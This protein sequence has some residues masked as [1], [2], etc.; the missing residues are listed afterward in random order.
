MATP[1]ATIVEWAHHALVAADLP[2]AFGGALALAYHVEE[3]RGTRDIDINVFVPAARAEDVL[4]ALDRA[5]WDAKDL[6]LALRDGQVRVFYED[7][8]LDLFLMNHPF[9]VQS[10]TNVEVVPFLDG[11]IPIL[12]ATDLAVYKV[13]FNRTK[14]WADLEAM[15]EV[16][17]FD[18]HVVLGWVVDL[19]GGD[20]ERVERLRSLSS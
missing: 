6:A 17:S 20:D 8:P 14:D 16:Q 12:S 3:P 18:L 10:A 5:G 13:F 9:H 11:M 19:L 7:T 4:Q 2:H 15:I 1:L